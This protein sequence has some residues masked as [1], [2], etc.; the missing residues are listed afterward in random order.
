MIAAIKP[1]VATRAT[2]WLR[3]L[4]ILQP[5]FQRRVRLL[6]PGHSV[7]RASHTTGVT[8]TRSISLSE[9]PKG[10]V[11]DFGSD[12]GDQFGLC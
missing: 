10:P 11:T 8:A 2:P 3:W 9:N 5:S 12:M 4:R 7:G 1:H 6:E